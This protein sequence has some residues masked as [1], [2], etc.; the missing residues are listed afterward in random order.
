MTDFKCSMAGIIEEAFGQHPTD[1]LSVFST[2]SEALFQLDALFQ[3]IAREAESD[4][5]FKLANVKHLLGIGRHIATDI[6]NYVDGQQQEFE[7]SLAKA[8]VLGEELA[9]G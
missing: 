4:G 1:V 5:G 6:G 2:A 8:G 9:R 3:A 7:K